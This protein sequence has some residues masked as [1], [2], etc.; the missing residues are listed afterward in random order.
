MGLLP[1]LARLEG[2]L[3]SLFTVESFVYVVMIH[4]YKYGI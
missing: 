2:M 1:L 4:M 3:W